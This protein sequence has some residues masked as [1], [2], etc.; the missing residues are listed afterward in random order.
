M[1]SRRL[2]ENVSFDSTYSPSKPTEQD[3]RVE[4]EVRDDRDSR[5]ERDDRD[6]REVRDDRDV[7]TEMNNNKLLTN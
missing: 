3:D 6:E 1:L 7:R 2:P 4:R 5:E